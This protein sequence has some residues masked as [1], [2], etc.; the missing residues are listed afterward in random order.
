[1]H[2]VRQAL[3]RGI[4]RCILFGEAEADNAI[5]APIGAAFVTD[6]VIY[7]HLIGG[8]IGCGMAEPM[9]QY[10]VAAGFDHV[11]VV[12]GAGGKAFVSGA[13]ISKFES[14]RSS[15]ASARDSPETSAESK[16]TGLPCGHAKKSR[17]GTA[18]LGSRRPS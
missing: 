1:M 3:Q 14:E 9:A 17:Q 5:I 2:R 7:P 15:E 8:D 18:M 10:V 16:A 4:D 6:G 13:D 11:V 12:T